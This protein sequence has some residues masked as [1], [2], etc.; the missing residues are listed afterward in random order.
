MHPRIRLL[1]EILIRTDAGI[2]HQGEQ[3]PVPQMIAGIQ[4]RLNLLNGKDFRQWPR[5]LQLDR[6]PHLAAP[7]GHDAEAAGTSAAS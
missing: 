1:I 2:E 4:D 5:C 7:F 6:P 3:Q